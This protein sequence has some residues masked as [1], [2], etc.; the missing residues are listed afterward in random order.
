MSILTVRKDAIVRNN[1]TVNKISKF[2]GGQFVSVKII[3]SDDHE[4]GKNY[5]D[6]TD[7]DHYIGLNSFSSSVAIRLPRDEKV[8]RE[9][10]VFDA[11]PFGGVGVTATKIIYGFDNPTI[12]FVELEHATTASQREFVTL[13]STGTTWE[14]LKH[15]RIP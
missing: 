13:I 8:G 10:I 7:T 1:L 9:I 5:Y 11:T 14:R 12:T 2:L 3:T 4:D 15:V 6:V